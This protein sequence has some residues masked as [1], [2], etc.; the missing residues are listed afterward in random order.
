MKKSYLIYILLLVL[1]CLI[2]LK[3]VAQESTIVSF[4]FD[5]K[6]VIKGAYSYDTTPVADI[7]FSAVTSKEKYEIGIEVEYAN[8][9][10]TYNTYGF[11]YNRKIIVR[12]NYTVLLGAETLG[13]VRSN[14]QFYSYGINAEVRYWIGNFGVSL[15]GNYKRRPDLIKIYNSN[16]KFVFSGFF[17]LK[18]RIIHK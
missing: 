6:L 1:F 17:N 13:I 4:G 12:D 16:K 14:R 2:G 18:Y 15:L 7:L 10:P 3:T 11:I 9:N 8:L 5:T